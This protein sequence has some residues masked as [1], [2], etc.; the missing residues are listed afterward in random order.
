MWKAPGRYR[1]ERAAVNAA[2]HR[3]FD[4]APANHARWRYEFDSS[5]ALHPSLRTPPIREYAQFVAEHP[6]FDDEPWESRYRDDYGY[7]VT[8]ADMLRQVAR[9]EELDKSTPTRT[10]GAV[11]DFPG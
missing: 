3:Q 9:D 2:A 10:S 11:R 5:Y 7:H 4:G 6:E 8:V 1:P